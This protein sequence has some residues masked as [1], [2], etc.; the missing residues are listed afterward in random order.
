M[1][2]PRRAA[3]LLFRIQIDPGTGSN[4]YAWNRKQLEKVRNDR[5]AQT[6]HWANV[7][8]QLALSCV[9]PVLLALA[10][11]STLELRIEKAPVLLQV[12]DRNTCHYLYQ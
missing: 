10:A 4:W 5:G 12:N 2:V 11:V 3:A 7:L 9:P 8:S 6:D 1:C